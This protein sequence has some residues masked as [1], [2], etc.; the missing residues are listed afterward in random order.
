MRAPGRPCGTAGRHLIARSVLF[1][2]GGSRAIPEKSFQSFFN[3]KTL[4][5]LSIG[6]NH[7]WGTKAPIGGPLRL[8]RG[9]WSGHG[10]PLRVQG[11][12]F[13][14]LWYAFLS[15]L[16]FFYGSDLIRQGSW[17]PQVRKRQ[18]VREYLRLW[19]KSKNIKS[20]IET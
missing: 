6:V 7:K 9:P 18:N 15:F 17:G 4:F 13:D 1:T 3:T 14:C 2:H 12:I 5:S 16:G 11:C 10:C 8:Q 19:E 20:T